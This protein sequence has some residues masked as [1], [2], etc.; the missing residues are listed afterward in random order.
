MIRFHIV[1]LFPNLC[2]PY[3]MDSILAR[4]IKQKKLAVSFYNPR[5]FVKGKYRKVW[6]DGNVQ[7]IVDDR[8]YGGGPGMVIRAE[9]VIDCV[10][11]I[12]KKIAQREARSKVK[13]QK[14][15]V[16]IILLGP[17]GTMFT[18]TFAKTAT[19]KYTDIIL[20]S[21]RYEGI[22]VRVK[23]IFKAE[24]VSIGDYVLTGGELPAL[25][26]IDCMARQVEGVLG[27]FDS[28]EEER[29]SS[30]EFY[31]RPEVLEYKGKKYKVPEVFISGNHK[32]IEERK[33][34]EL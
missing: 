21:G 10:D 31:T 19:K 14:S 7:K 11:S 5:E 27:N 29:A 22:D 34:K 4:A 17:H 3:L 30:N 28:R 33:R 13:S 32:K 15:K 8:P 26:M 9:P 18:T 6:P 23:Q 20:L 2:E 25:V 12:L 1:T 24:E 16:K